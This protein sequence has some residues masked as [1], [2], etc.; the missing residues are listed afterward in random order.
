LYQSF[1]EIQTVAAERGW[2]YRSGLKAVVLLPPARM[3][4]IRLLL[5]Q[6][7]TKQGVSGFQK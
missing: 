2:F 3:H 7:Q 1:F 5:L 6:I 4:S